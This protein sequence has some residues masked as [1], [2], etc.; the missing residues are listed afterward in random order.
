MR[1]NSKTVLAVIG[2]TLYLLLLTS[3]MAANYGY[4]CSKCG[5]TMETGELSPTVKSDIKYLFKSKGFSKCNHDW[6][7]GIY[8]AYPEPISDNRLVLVKKKNIYGAIVLVQ[9]SLSTG[10]AKYKWWYRTDGKGDFASSE[11]KSGTDI[12]NDF[13]EI[14]F[15][16]FNITWSPNEDGKGFIYYECISD[17]M[18]PDKDFS[19]CLTNK[20]GI[21]GINATDAIWKFKAYGDK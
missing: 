9:Q 8:T 6:R 12:C 4:T 7:R 19:I 5:S 18:I 17:K 20:T 1:I 21:E 2:L 13:D 11:T 10:N 14:T 15:G 16:P 3:C